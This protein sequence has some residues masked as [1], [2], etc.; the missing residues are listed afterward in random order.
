MNRAWKI[1]TSETYP[2]AFETK[3]TIGNEGIWEHL[4]S[5]VNKETLIPWT[6]T[7]THESL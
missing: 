5:S 1:P 7:H 3:L 4:D 6:H 2:F